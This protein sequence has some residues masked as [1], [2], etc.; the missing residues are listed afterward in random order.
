MA[1]ELTA[2]EILGVPETASAD[3]IEAAYRRRIREFHP[4]L[5]RGDETWVEP[6]DDA[7]AKV[8][9][10][11]R[12]REYD[13]W[14]ASQRADKARKEAEEQAVAKASPPATPEP[15]QEVPVTP[16]PDR[17][18]S[19]PSEPTPKASSAPEPPPAPPPQS[20][21]P[22]AARRG[23]AKLRGPVPWSAAE[24]D[25]R[26][27]YQDYGGQYEAE[28]IFNLIGAGL[29]VI[30]WWFVFSEGLA[31]FKLW[32]SPVAWAPL[33]VFFGAGLLRR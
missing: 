10:K 16:P 11:T 5:N 13:E 14:L 25:V 9:S 6:L 3:E 27:A 28:E 4:D 1:D 24:P 31:G 23:I 12:R 18:N 32:W 26:A 22:S 19:A 20:T 33:V 30:A 15:T 21:E 8:G 29:L 2:Y 17:S 7:Y